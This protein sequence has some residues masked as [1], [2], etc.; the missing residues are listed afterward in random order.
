MS[1]TNWQCYILGSV[2]GHYSIDVSLGFNRCH[3]ARNRTKFAS[4]VWWVVVICRVGSSNYSIL[5]NGVNTATKWAMSRYI[6]TRQSDLHSR[7]T[8]GW[9]LYIARTNF[10]HMFTTIWAVSHLVPSG[11]N[12]FGWFYENKHTITV[13]HGIVPRVVKCLHWIVR[14][15]CSHLRPVLSPDDASQKKRLSQLDVLDILAAAYMSALSIIR[16]A[17]RVLL[18]TFCRAEANRRRI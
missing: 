13:V 16:W 7:I 6:L 3:N 2:L 11:C 12:T 14:N 10:M 5:A 18:K 9:S 8:S 15:N 1:C 17:A 4:L